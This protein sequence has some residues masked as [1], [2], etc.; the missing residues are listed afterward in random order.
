MSSFDILKP[1]NTSNRK[2]IGAWAFYDWANSVYN[3]IITSAIFPIFYAAV[4][5]GNK[6]MRNGQQVDLVEFFGR[7]F[8]N[9]ELYTYV[10]SFSFL[11]VVL[12]VPILS[13]IADYMGNKKRFLQ[14]FCYLGAAACVS[15][16]WFDVDHL[17]RSMFSVFIASIGFWGSLVYYNSFLPEIASKRL[18]D[19]ISARGF[20]LGYIG[21]VLLL[22]TVLIMNQKFG[23]D[24]K[25]AFI[26]V[27][28]WWAGFA[29]YTYY[30]L[31]SKANKHTGEIK[32]VIMNGYR[33]I[34]KVWNELK[35]IG[36]I[37]H[38]LLAYFVYNMGVQTIMILAVVFAEKEINWPLLEN[39]EKD[40]S[41]LIISIII[42]QLIAVVGATIMSR[43]SRKYGNIKVLM[44]AVLIWI[45]LTIAAYFT[46]QPSQFY[47]LAAVVGFVMGGIQA[48]SRSTYSK[49]L[50]KTNDHASYFSFYDVMEKVGLIIGP[51]LFG[52]IEGLTGN[53]RMSVLVLMIIFII[54]FLLLLKLNKK[55]KEEK[56]LELEP[57]V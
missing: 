4:T 19:K 30:Y 57:M 33:E 45:L 17:E 54:G 53:M 37:K 56:M 51:F 39:G 18:H 48:L 50:P 6:G 2:V 40:S 16:Y 42:I 34:R 52:L 5:A 9:T 11:I 36:S 24:I 27:G 46:Y 23:R 7:S 10:V 14:F 32:K 49:M 41:G 20:S 13:G 3:L 1:K 43:M 31:P 15:L 22:V 47:F 8:I 28:I 44:I 35:Q 25:E 29:Q 21:S 38:Y 26:L 12:I 55:V